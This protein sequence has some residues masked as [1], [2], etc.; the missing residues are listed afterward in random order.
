MLRCVQ[1]GLRQKGL[2]SAS[3]R[4]ALASRSSSMAG[5]ISGRS[6][7]WTVQ[8]ARL[9]PTRG[10]V[11]ALS[12]NPQSGD[13]KADADGKADADDTKEIVLTPGEQV[14]AASRLS[15]WAGMFGLAVVCAYFIGKELIPTK[16][17]PNT[18][19]N[20]SSQVIREDPVV[21]RQFGDKLKFYGKD[22]GGHREGRRNF[23]EHTEY[24]D[25]DDGTKRTRV[26][27]NMEGQFAGAFCFAEVSSDMP[28]GEFVYILVQ[29]KRNGQV[30]TVVDNRAALTAQRL[31]GGN[32][33]SASAM[34]QLLGGGK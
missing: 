16:M 4:I 24:T 34:Q 8:E 10:W 26:R 20:K 13:K 32:K 6:K 14:V 30:I 33:E 19:F 9:Q 22:H 31:A 23:I 1:S 2:T 7:M 28:S 27:F 11:R 12:S 29:D 18:V 5:T 3:T 25:P 21:A 15:M 17:S